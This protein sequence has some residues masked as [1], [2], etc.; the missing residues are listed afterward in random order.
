MLFRSDD[1]FRDG[2]RRYIARHAYGNTV[3]DDLWQSLDAHA[4]RP[5]RAIARDLTLQAGVPLIVERDAR[6]VAGRTQV[7]LSQQQFDVD[8]P[9][10]ARWHAPVALAVLGG[11][12]ARA[13]VTGAAPQRVS[14]PGCGPLVINAGQAS[15]LRVRYSDAGLAALTERFAQLSVDDRLGLL[16]DTQALAFAGQLPMGAWLGLLRQV[17]AQQDPLVTGMLIDQLTDL[18]NLVAG[19]PTRP[20]F[21]AFARSLLDP[22]FA[23]VGWQAAE[24]ESGDAATLRVDLIVA[25]GTFDDAAVVAEAQRRFTRFRA[26]PASLQGDAREAVLKVVAIRADANDWDALHALAKAATT[27]LEKAEDYEL[28]GYVHDRDQAQRAL[29]LAISGEP[30]ATIAGRLLRSIGVVHPGPTLDFVADHW[31]AVEPLYGDG[32]AATIAARFFDTGADRAMLPRLDAFVEAHVPSATRGRIVKNAALIRYR[33][34]VRDQ[35]LPQADRWIA[36]Q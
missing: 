30:P 18:D 20:A 7:T 19:L 9:R 23:R 15:Y 10:V 27:E 3:T 11:G 1:A 6:C 12:N 17:P 34:G 13:V 36:A 31:A 2:V 24:G 32:A 29:A 25:L 8:A 22:I 33:A 5:V 26:D 4:A 35:R 28:L 16:A 14:V 21:R